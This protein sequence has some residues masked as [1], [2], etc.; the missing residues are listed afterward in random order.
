MTFA[1]GSVPAAGFTLTPPSSNPALNL[2]GDGSN[3]SPSW[4]YTF[5][6]APTPQQQTRP[7]MFSLNNVNHDVMGTV[8]GVNAAVSGGFP[9]VEEDGGGGWNP[10]PPQQGLGS[11][12]GKGSSGLQ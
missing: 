6:R 9:E 10:P 3:P 5:P 11:R 12:N 2:A 8:G 7:Y 1:S 4:Q